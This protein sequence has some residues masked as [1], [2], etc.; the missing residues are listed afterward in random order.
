MYRGAQLGNTDHRLL[1]SD[2]E[3]KLK[4]Q[5]QHSTRPISDTHRLREPDLQHAYEC[6][7]TNR[8]NGLERA[9]DWET[10]K[11]AITEAAEETLGQGRPAPKQPWISQQALDVINQSRE[12]RLRGSVE[13]YR[14]L[15][16]VRNTAIRTDKEAYWE[17]Q[18]TQME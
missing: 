12:A 17:A 6:S 1:V 16:A 2:L 7:I 4:A 10:F 8:F 18:A 3:L 9:Y 11:T 14:R 15:N 13:E 5:A